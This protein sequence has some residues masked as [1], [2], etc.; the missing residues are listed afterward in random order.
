[1]ARWDAV[2]G[3]VAIPDEEVL[4]GE[5][6]LFFRWEVDESFAGEGLD[7]VSGEL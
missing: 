4:V 6:A 5:E 3:G 7:S 2:A 1:M